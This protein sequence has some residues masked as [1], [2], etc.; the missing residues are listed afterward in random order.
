LPSPG[1]WAPG[2]GQ[3]TQGQAAAAATLKGVAVEGSQRFTP[4]QLATAGGL[5]IGKPVTKESLQLAADELGR[6]G[7]FRKVLYR[8]KTYLDGVDLVFELEDAPLLP[9]HFDN[10]PWFSDADLIARL[11]EAV[12]LFKGEA[13]SQ[14]IILQD[15]TKALQAFLAEQGITAAVENQVIARPDGAGDMLMFTVAGASLKIAGFEFQDPIAAESRRIAQAKQD[16]VGKA[17]SRY[18][19]EMFLMEQVRP[20]YVDRGHIRVEFDTPRARFSGDPNKPL[21]DVTVA[22]AIQPG[23]V[24]RWGGVTWRG[25]KAVESAALDALVQLPVGQPANGTL[26]A[27]TWLKVEGEYGRRGYLDVKVT[28]EAAYD[29]AAQRVAYTVTI[30][31]GTQYRMGELVITGLSVV[32]ERKIREAWGI[33]KGTTFDRAYFEE[34]LES[35]VKKA[36]ADYVVHYQDI[37]RWLRTNPDARVVDVLL[38]FR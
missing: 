29:D 27:G 18:A 16:L 33:A 22:I 2:Q 21:G 34:F 36:F 24:Y 20:V 12:V 31:E 30:S 5:E 28:P 25:N 3:A 6:L 13:P 23:P 11:K 37:G 8:Y 15:M 17:Y 32:A 10:F 38:D 26:I 9:V 14:G 1:V 4:E 19:I 7:L 35:G